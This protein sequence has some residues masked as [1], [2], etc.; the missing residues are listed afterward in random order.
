MTENTAASVLATIRR[1]NLNEQTLRAVLERDAASRSLVSG[2]GGKISRKHYAGMFGYTRAALTKFKDTLKE[3]E[4]RYDVATGPLDRFEEMRIFLELTYKNRELGFRDGKLTRT[5]FMENFQL[6]GGS[7]LSR[8]PAI[9]SLFDEYDARAVRERYLPSNRSDDLE[10]LNKFLEEGPALNADRLTVNRA[11]I[12]KTLG[13]PRFQLTINPFKEMI[14]VWESEN[15]SR[16]A[17]SK[18]TPIVRGKVYSFERLTLYWGERFVQRL[19]YEFGRLAVSK[20]SVTSKREY[21]ILV[22]LFKW[23]GQSQSPMCRQ[24]VQESIDFGRVNSPDGWEDV[25]YEYR[26]YI[27]SRVSNGSA[28]AYTSDSWLAALRSILEQLSNCRIFPTIPTPLPGIKRAARLGCRVRSVA[29]AAS[30][31][32]GEGKRDYVAFVEE[33]LKAANVIARTEFRSD[34]N[35]EFLAGLSH[36]ISTSKNLPQDPASAVLLVLNKRLNVIENHA[37]KIVSEAMAHLERGRR[38][39]DSANFDSSSF[40]QSYFQCGLS[41]FE[42]GKIGAQFF[43]IADTS[44]QG[45]SNLVLGRFLSLIVQMHRGIPPV[46]SADALGPYGQF[47]TRRYA[48][49]GGLKNIEP[50]LIPSP[51]VVGA[52]LTLY[53][54]ESGSNVSVGRT[55]E[56]DCLEESD[57]EGYRRITGFKARAKGKPIIVDLPSDSNAVKAI[58]WLA[59]A[60]K[61]LRFEAGDD[62]DRLFLMRVGSRVQL[63][64]PHWYTNWFKRFVGSV[65]EL[66]GLHLVPSMLRPSVL[67]HAALSNDGRLSVGAALG[68]HRTSVSQGYQ[69]KWPTRNQYDHQVRQFQS[70]LESIVMESIDEAAAKIGVSNEE[71]AARIEMV[72]KTGFGTFCLDR[73]GRTVGRT[74]TCST[75]DC[76]ND[77]PNMVI[78]AEVE[79]IA[80]LQ[81]WRTS[82]REVQPEWE[83][84]RPERWDQVWLPW[85]CLIDVVEEKMSRGK[86]VAIW[87]KARERA[88][89]ISCQAG[90]SPPRPF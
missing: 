28:T 78:I 12:R 79:S 27:I 86:L 26:D 43:P 48:A 57:I 58:D 9:R 74:E 83:R 41:S 23:I 62:A 44:E 15:R 18:I 5:E 51:D 72:A 40:K 65:E 53:L 35:A 14:E 50:M 59:Q 68:Q 42:R 80:A 16:L 77:C 21:L 29:E 90:F 89:T 63:M 8:Y 17:V 52:I 6:N 55:L 66:K 45:H 13:L 73:K 75:L 81:I 84:D 33:H 49:Y 47:F 36:E 39:L 69:Q 10:R 71:L 87:N 82:L 38:L 3:F 54:I 70:S 85:L 88:A 24:I 7:F 46:A 22:D 56:F 19:G 11:V 4:E 25:V 31:G 1:G 30:D 60:A 37:V 61:P 32:R 64:T 20:P 67:L 2:R 76:W 34:E